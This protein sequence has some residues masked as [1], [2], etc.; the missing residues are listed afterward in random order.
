MNEQ[1]NEYKNT[2]ITILLHIYI[3]IYSKK[4]IPFEP[5]NSSE[6]FNATGIFPRCLGKKLKREHL[7]F[8]FQTI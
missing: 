5:K 4:N 8:K 6:F 2:K 7:T 3:Y 1:T